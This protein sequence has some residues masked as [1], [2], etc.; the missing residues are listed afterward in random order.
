M[1]STKEI[2][3]FF[4]LL[5]LVFFIGCDDN[6]TNPVEQ[7]LELSDVINIVWTLESF[8]VVGQEIGLSSF[9]PF[10]LIYRE[11]TF[12]GDD[13]C[14]FFGATFEVKNDSIFPQDFATTLILCDV[15]SFP[16]EHLTE[17]YRLQINKNKLKIHTNNSIYTYKSKFVNSVKNSP[18]IGKEWILTSSNAPEFEL[19]KT[20]QLLP[21][22]IF[23]ENR[24]LDISWY[25]SDNNILGCN[26]RGGLYGIGDGNTILFYSKLNSS[27]S[28]PDDLENLEDLDLVE[29]ILKSSSYS[30]EGNLLTLSN[31]SASTLFEFTVTKILK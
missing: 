15:K 26:R 21:T 16:W 31:E 30:V 14:N 12:F 3:T 2:Q 6:S 8:E 25:C 10:N 17:P 9:E 24:G 20:H 28:R 1:N 18:L 7:S 23:D 13:G 11:D 29:R 5:L 22:L 27:Y 19:I 4:L